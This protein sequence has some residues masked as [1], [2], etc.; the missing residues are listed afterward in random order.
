[1]KDEQQIEA[2]LIF[3]E[4]L[5]NIVSRESELL[6][7][8]SAFRIFESEMRTPFERTKTPLQGCYAKFNPESDFDNFFECLTTGFI[9]DKDRRLNENGT[10]YRDYRLYGRNLVMTPHSRE[11]KLSTLEDEIRR[12]MSRESLIILFHCMEAFESFLKRILEF[13]LLIGS[14]PKQ[15]FSEG[16]KKKWGEINGN[17]PQFILKIKGKNNKGLLKLIRRISP[18]YKNHEAENSLYLPFN[19]WY[20]IMCEIRHITVHNPF[21]VSPK[22]RSMLDEEKYRDIFDKT[23][24]INNKN[25]ILTTKSQITTQTCNLNSFA[26]LIYNSLI[27]I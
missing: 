10:G 22:L 27:Q 12:I 3:N 25:Q 20:D 16:E 21:K 7:L 19:L 23:F 17:I 5:N 2:K 26:F 14:D 18:E 1:M 11:L 8:S 24:T 4:Y 15:W 6:T 9:V 13:T